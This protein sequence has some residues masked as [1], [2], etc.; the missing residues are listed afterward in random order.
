MMRHLFNIIIAVAFTTS[1]GF[2]QKR[3]V[4]T[5]AVDFKKGE[6]TNAQQRI[7]EAV[8][9]SETAGDP[10]AWAVRGD[11][12]KAIG[13][14][15]LKKYQE[16]DMEKYKEG[17]AEVN[18]AIKS[19]KKALELDDKE[20]YKKDCEV[21]L[22]NISVTYFNESNNLRSAGHKEL[23]YELANKAEEIL[24]DPTQDPGFSVL[25]YSLK[26]FAAT[27][28]E[29]YDEAVSSFQK[30]IEESKALDKPDQR[31][32]GV[33]PSVYLTLINVLTRNEKYQEAFNYIEKAKEKYDSD[34]MKERLSAAELDA[35]VAE[36]KLEKRLPELEKKANEN[37]D[38]H[39]LHFTLGSAYEQ[40]GE[41][42]KA[43]NAYIRSTEV[44]NDF[45]YGLY[46]AGTVYYEKLGKAEHS[47]AEQSGISQQEREKFYA[48]R[49]TYF[50]KAI[51][52]FQQIVNASDEGKLDLT[53]QTDNAIISNSL[54][55]LRSIYGL[56]GEMD[57]RSEIKQKMEEKGL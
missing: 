34:E 51:P 1:V 14:K 16:E 52:F 25:L 39:W 41:F 49:D 17:V 55:A 28:L 5:A 24:P 40:T 6:Y 15:K 29:K 3:A 19:Y 13:E 21:G 23:A 12:Y 2:A 36:N 9:N 37:P 57:K 42:E 32:Q 8:K 11:V 44:K 56:T 10:Q 7:D 35:Y 27:D 53:N 48:D 30:F 22:Y 50:K 31:V 33:E 54:I 46:N 47:K 38:N 18:E 43:A 26:G 4:R 20:K 45:Y